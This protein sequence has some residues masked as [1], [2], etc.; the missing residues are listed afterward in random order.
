MRERGF[1]IK[2]KSA[3]LLPW[4]WTSGLQNCEDI[5]LCCVSHQIVLLRYGSP[6]KPVEEG[7]GD[8]SP[9]PC[10][11]PGPSLGTPLIPSMQ[12]MYSPLLCC[13]SIW[14]SASPCSLHPL[15]HSVRQDPRQLTTASHELSTSGLQEAYICA[16]INS[17]VQA[18]HSPAAA[19]P[20][21][22]ILTA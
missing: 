8:P 22:P 15:I 5:D 9:L 2:S 20:F 17:S 13:F 7:F 3:L 14:E 18:D 1:R 16:H 21:F 12:V 6:S 11:T 10:S 4:F 19:A